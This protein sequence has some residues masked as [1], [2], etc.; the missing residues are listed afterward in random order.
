MSEISKVSHGDRLLFE[1]RRLVQEATKTRLRFAA[2]MAIF[3]LLGIASVVAVLHAESQQPAHS[4]HSKN[5][6]LSDMVIS[7]GLQGSFVQIDLQSEGSTTDQNV[8]EDARTNI[9]HDIS[10]DDGI[11]SVDD[12]VVPGEH[13]D[14]S[15]SVSLNDNDANSQ[16]DVSMH[17]S[18][19][20][21][22]SK[23]DSTISVD[24]DGGAS[25]R[26]RVRTRTIER[27]RGT[28]D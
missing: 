22:D 28:N 9:S 10:I 5:S 2:T 16:L 12:V 7:G 25:A 18:D 19:T 27:R 3:I 1:T 15:A 14:G 23:S 6:A 26:T 20:N 24:I 13:Q 8:S 4:L 11:V 21:E 17:A